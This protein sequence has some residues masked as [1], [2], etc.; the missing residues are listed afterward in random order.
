VKNREKHLAIISESLFSS[1]SLENSMKIALVGTIAL[2][3]ILI[4]GQTVAAEGKDVYAKACSVCHVAGV[5][6]AP[7]P[8]DKA[9]WA[10]RIKQGNDVLAASVIKGKGAM[11]PRAGNSA[12]SDSD[13]KA[14]VDYMIS[15][16]K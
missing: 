16:V 14:A 11:P 2:I 7:K 4:A 1:A 5:A 6:N 8:G 13:I 10:P 9:A 15:E 12:L 3:A